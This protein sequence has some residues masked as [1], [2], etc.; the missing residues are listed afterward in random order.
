MKI[1]PSY[2]HQPI[3]VLISSPHPLPHGVQIT[4]AASVF[5]STAQV[6]LVMITMCTGGANGGGY[7]PT[8]GV[9]V[10]VALGLYVLSGVVN[11]FTIQVQ[12]STGAL[13]ISQQKFTVRILPSV[14][15]MCSKEQTSPPTL[16]FLSFSCP[17][18]HAPDHALTN[19]IEC[20]FLYST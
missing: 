11:T 20:T 15:T 7:I 8:P 17:I 19:T 2:N 6:L 18:P 3:Q 9:F 10:A 12:V 16:V 1:H 5:F 4:A 13:Q 14:F